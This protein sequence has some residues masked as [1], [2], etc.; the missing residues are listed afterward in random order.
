MVQV[1]F[2]RSHHLPFNNSHQY[3]SP[4]KQLLH[5]LTDIDKANM[6][7]LLQSLIPE[8]GAGDLRF[9]QLILVPIHLSV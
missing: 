2:P 3:V 9:P 5:Q 7:C 1:I 4:K 6:M 8:L